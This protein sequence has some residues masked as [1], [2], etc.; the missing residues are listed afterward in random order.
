MNQ[1][2]SFFFAI[3]VILLAVGSAGCSLDHTGATAGQAS[4]NQDLQAAANILGESLSNDE[5]GI[6]LSL[7]DALTTVSEDGFLTYNLPGNRPTTAAK[8]SGRGSET[9]YHHIYRKKNGI[10]NVS[11]KRKV[12]DA[13]FSK[14]V[15][16][17]LRYRY[18][19]ENGT[20]IEFPQRYSNRIASIYYDARHKGRITTLN[21]QSRFVRQDTFLISELKASVLS[22]DGVHHG[23]GS[24]EITP[25]QKPS[26]K[27]AYE[28]EIN[29][30]NINAPASAFNS[31]DDFWKDVNGTLSWQ[32]TIGQGAGAKK[33][34]GTIK[35]AGAGTA[36]LNFRSSS[37]K[38]QVNLNSGDVK[39]QEEEFE[40][41]INSVDVAAQSITLLNGRTLYLT[42]ET[43]IE[44]D[45]YTS[46]EAVENA[47]NSGVNVWAEGEGGMQN[48]RFIVTEVEFE[49]E[50][51]DDDDDEQDENSIE[52]DAMVTS[53]SIQMSSFVLGDQAVINIDEN[54]VIDNDG[55][56]MSLQEVAEALNDGLRVSAEG[57]ARP[58][59]Q[60]EKAELT[61]TEVKFE[62]VDQDDNDDDD[63]NSE[64]D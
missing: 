21:K 12:Q 55:D 53:V 45:D 14:T 43:E 32:L 42:K 20:N 62:V 26:F 24:I 56:Y 41:R 35:M 63:N 58:D 18:Q 8:R 28:L 44:Q 36:M 49:E 2:I 10:H 7:N 23:S 1:H 40:G 54:T 46:L 22:V 57:E 13:L 50:D 16:D 25:D 48:G 15:T 19:A 60:S 3:G 31:K 29:L 6:I 61:A 9:N 64:E 51:T 52:F 4:G 47:L 11:F 33:M 39:D 17:S 5:S 37:K 59:S 27:R 34:G 30:L 38:Y